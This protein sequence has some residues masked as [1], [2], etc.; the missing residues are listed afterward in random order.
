VARERKRLRRLPGERITAPILRDLL[1]TKVIG[2]R[3]KMPGD[4]EL[5]ELAG[6]LEHWR[7]A[8]SNEQNLRTR[9]RLQEAAL[10]AVKTL[11]GAALALAEHDAAN[12]VATIKG[13][14]PEGIRRE[15]GAREAVSR[16][17][18]GAVVVLGNSPSLHNRPLSFGATGWKF[19]ACVLP[20]DFANALK[21]ANPTYTPGISEAGP[22][23]RVVAAVVPLITG[24]EPSVA[25]VAKQ[26]KDARK[27]R[28]KQAARQKDVP[29]RNILSW[30]WKSSHR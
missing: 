14:A 15:L 10:A 17:L 19:L 12:L 1:Q 30:K 21:P 18:V 16:E 2:N 22:L 9:E 13:S 3:L 8:F 25:S 11:H 28:R 24:E 26:L 4:G 7:N 27:A 5:T 20:D 23:A 29:V 6:I